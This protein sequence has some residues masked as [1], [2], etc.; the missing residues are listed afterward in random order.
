MDNQ[1]WRYTHAVDKGNSQ[2]SNGSDTFLH[3]DKNDGE[4]TPGVKRV[5]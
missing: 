2:K 3:E 1:R 5:P 4:I